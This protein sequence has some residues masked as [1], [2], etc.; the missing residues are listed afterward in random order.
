MRPLLFLTFLLLWGCSA[1]DIQAQQIN[2]SK[3]A[4]DYEQY[5]EPTIKDR[6]FKHEDIV[7]LINRLKPPFRVQQE[8][9]SIEGRSINRVTL[10][11]GP[12]K[13][14]LWSQMHGDETTAT[15]AL[16]DLFNFFSKSDGYNDFRQM[17]LDQITLVFIPMLNPDGA[18]QFER[19]NALGID[20]NRDALRLQTP[21]AQILKRV[22]DELNA[23]WGFNLHD[24][25]RYYSAGQNPHTAAFSF[26]A[27]AYN[28]QK[29]VNSVRG[30]AMRLIAPMNRV[31]Q[32]FI[33]GKVGKY[34]DDFE[35]RA[36]GDNIQR[37]GTSTIL[38]E[39]GGLKDDPEKQYLR[40]LHFILLLKAFEAI[41][42]KSYLQEIHADYYGL[43]F[44]DSN[45]F[46]DLILR[47]VEVQKNGKWYTVD[48][49]FR[50]LEIGLRGDRSFYYIGEIADVG[51]L[52]VYYGYE[53]LEAKGYQVVPG[54]L[55]Q[56]V[57]SDASSLKRLN[58]QQLLKQG[59]TT[60][61]M[62]KVPYGNAY[63][64]YP[65]HL[66]PATHRQSTELEPGDR[67]SLIIKKDGK[68][69]YAVVNGSLHK[70]N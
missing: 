31:L 70:I 54:K 35:P 41:A 12:V 27:P 36:F 55:Y 20:L 37:W 25:S 30:N 21:E 48:I 51:D 28:Y 16:M 47:E 59:I 18:E 19:R 39:V 49:A 6:R 50:R 10:G 44:N 33:P 57:L 43:P 58:H 15:M 5:K 45:N 68:I 2:I 7:P 17:L 52:S 3:L 9:Q 29:D 26:L 64:H 65:L 4:N 32:Q 53:E 14:L 22:R 69:V 56:D 61:R 42:D 38:I 62:E 13:V 46:H 1:P 66:V 24:Q 63:L 40:K 34:N 23:D 11:N 67:T 60:V 8:G